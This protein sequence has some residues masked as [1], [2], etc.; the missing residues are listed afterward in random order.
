MTSGRC[1]SLT[2][3]IRHRL[4]GWCNPKSLGRCLG[5]WDTSQLAISAR[6]LKCHDVARFSL[7]LVCYDNDTHFVSRY[8]AF[9]VK[10]YQSKSR[11]QIKLKHN[12]FSVK[13]QFHTMGTINNLAVNLRVVSLR[14]KMKCLYQNR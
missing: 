8:S 11:C 5:K 7:G 12:I 2:S 6:N 1:S 14:P 13:L 4:F 10:Y 3:L 9:K